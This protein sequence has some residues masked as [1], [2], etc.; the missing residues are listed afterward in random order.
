MGAN[1]LNLIKTPKIFEKEARN[2]DR[3]KELVAK[4]ISFNYLAEIVFQKGFHANIG[5]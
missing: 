5:K 1:F 4:Q 2:F 3:L